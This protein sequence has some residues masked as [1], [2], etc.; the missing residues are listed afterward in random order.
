M[1]WTVT[2]TNAEEAGTVTLSPTTRPRVG[3]EITAALTD[4][5]SV[6]SANTTGSITTGVTWQW[7]KRATTTNSA[8]VNISGATS[9]SYTPADA[10]ADYFLR[11]TAR[12]AAG[13]SAVATTTQTVLALTATPNDGTVTISPAQPVV[14]TAVTATLSDLD[15]S[16]T[17]LSWQW[18]WATTAT[19]ATSSWTNIPGATSAS[20][21]P[22]AADAG[23]YLRATASYSD[24]VDGAGQTAFGTSANA[25]TTVV[26]ADPVYDGIIPGTQPDGIID[27]AEVIKAVQDYFDDI[28]DADKVLDIVKLYFQN[29]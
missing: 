21:T 28:I 17:G 10:D 22:V 13:Q 27:A 9:A 23:R 14:G 29:F 24:A 12:Y 18:S 3:T 2:V 4:P 16:P 11:A 7:A 26:P 20:Y 8:Y 19:A 6:T 1:T 25:V 5:D 15:G